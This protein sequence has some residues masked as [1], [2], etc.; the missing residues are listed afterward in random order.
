M[1]SKQEII[2]ERKTNL[3]LPEDPPVESDWNSADARNVNV[4]AGGQS[5]DVSLGSGDS[6]GLREPATGASAARVDGDELKTNTAGLDVGRT[7]KDGLDGLPNDAVTRDAKDKAGLVDTT[8][9]DY[10]YPNESDPSE[11]IKK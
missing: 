3:P 11:G 6:S 9:K 5:D 1:A 4:G 7:A 8:G 10:G 2:E